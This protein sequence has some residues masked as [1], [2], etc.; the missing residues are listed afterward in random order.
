MLD[1]VLQLKRSDGT[2][3][4]SPGTPIVLLVQWKSGRQSAVTNTDMKLREPLKLIDF[5]ESRI[6]YQ[7]RDAAAASSAGGAVPAV[8]Q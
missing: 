8:S 2:D 5:Y 7:K 4:P 1:K 3:E 6:R